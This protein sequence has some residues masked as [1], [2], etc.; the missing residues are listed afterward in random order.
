MLALII[1]FVIVIAIILICLFFI[2]ANN[3][4]NKK[5]DNM[6]IDNANNVDSF[7]SMAVDNAQDFKKSVGDNVVSIRNLGTVPRVN[8]MENIPDDYNLFDVYPNLI[9]PALDQTVCG[10]CYAFASSVAVSDCLRIA[11][12]KYNMNNNA[13]I[14]FPL[15]EWVEW[16]FTAKGATRQFL[17]KEDVEE[18]NPYRFD[19]PEFNEHKY[20]VL[21][22]ISPLGLAILEPDYDFFGYK[23]IVGGDICTGGN[24]ALTLEVLL[25]WNFLPGECRN[26]NIPPIF[27]NW[28]KARYVPLSEA[29]PEDIMT[30]N[31][32]Q[33]D[34]VYLCPRNEEINQ[35]F[36]RDDCG[37][38]FNGGCPVTYMDDYLHKF[39]PTLL[40]GFSCGNYDDNDYCVPAETTAALYFI[41]MPFSNFNYQINGFNILSQRNL[42][43]LRITYGSENTANIKDMIKSYII[44][45]G[46]VIVNMRIPEALFNAYAIN[47]R[48]YYTRWDTGEIYYPINVADDLDKGITPSI[49]PVYSKPFDQDRGLHS[50]TIVGWG[51][52]RNSKGVIK[53]YWLLR[54]S[55]GITW[56]DNGNFMILDE[57]EQ[58]GTYVCTL[59]TLIIN[60][61]PQVERIV[62][63]YK[64]YPLI[65]TS[66]ENPI[67][68]ELLM[69][70]FD[71]K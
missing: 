58:M 9:T 65:T 30:C 47:K 16:G 54:N 36:A 34:R 50:L 12:H 69:Q 45:S 7:I 63:H 40:T 48:E 21:N 52:C 46:P 33:G 61:S 2:F 38:I 49:F 19:L 4:N 27:P 20:P 37:K 22:N 24:P 59:S 41:Q 55:W 15:N 70:F 68:I 11:I 25:A 13:N 57:D 66:K 23:G 26:A 29:K 31:D 44:Q 14:K 42:R 28:V 5:N 1:A 53:D 51:K 60:I 32:V 17:A 67:G 39:I 18:K 8:I 64:D 6:V 43:T 3:S 35:I 56:A 71:N 10:D 62:K